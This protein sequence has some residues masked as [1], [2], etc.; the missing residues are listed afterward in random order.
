MNYLVQH[1]A[2]DAFSLGPFKLAPCLFDLGAEK[3][4]NL[5]AA[6]RTCIIL[7]HGPEI[8]GGCA[9]GRGTGASVAG[10]A[11]AP[12]T[13]AGSRSAGGNTC[14]LRRG[15]GL[16]RLGGRFMSGALKAS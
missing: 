2:I 8:E 11:I 14:C 5:M 9:G 3:V 15:E 10:V 6:N 7:A 12:L 13:V 1:G 4:E 16:R